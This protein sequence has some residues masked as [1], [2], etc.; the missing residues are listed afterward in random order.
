M[1]LQGSPGACPAV[2]SRARAQK[3][4]VPLPLHWTVVFHE[5]GYQCEDREA[6]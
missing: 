4:P 2:R 3:N 5:G 1:Q 6:L